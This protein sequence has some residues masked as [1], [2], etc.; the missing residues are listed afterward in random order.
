[1]AG[2][3]LCGAACRLRA[4]ATL[5]DGYGARCR[6]S[7]HAGFGLDGAHR[8]R[9]PGR[10]ARAT[11][12]SLDDRRS[13]RRERVRARS[14]TS[15]SPYGSSKYVYLKNEVLV[16]T[17]VD[18]AATEYHDRRSPVLVAGRPERAM[19][20]VVRAGPQA[21]EREERVEDQAARPRLRRLGAGDRLDRP[22]EERRHD[23]RLLSLY[24]VGKVVVLNVAAGRGSKINAT[25]ARKL[26]KLGVAHID[27]ALIPILISPRR[28]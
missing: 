3:R 10:E 1:M 14:S 26:G 17:S 2:K 11:R 27:A 23:E 8:R 18:N 21:Q 6:D 12:A 16:T 20:E 15:A 9:R 28:P 24:R 19:V 25:D 7:G 22:H 13:R 4:V 5:S